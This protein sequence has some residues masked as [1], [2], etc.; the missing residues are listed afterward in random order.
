M[1]WVC[2]ILLVVCV[3]EQRSHG[4]Y[5]HSHN[6]FSYAAINGMTSQRFVD[7]A[8]SGW[9]VASLDSQL[10]QFD[11]FVDYQQDYTTILQ[12]LSLLS[13]GDHYV[14]TYS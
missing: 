14:G 13:T 10:C 11:R 1:T 5:D 7:S 3:T 9:H 12:D 4:Q 8:G 6:Q 2:L